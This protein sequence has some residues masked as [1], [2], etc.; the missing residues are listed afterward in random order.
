MF[1]LLPF[2]GPFAFVQ[3][4]SPGNSLSDVIQVKAKNP[5]R[6][7]LMKTYELTDTDSLHLDHGAKTF[8][9]CLKL[10]RHGKHGPVNLCMIKKK[11]L[12]SQTSTSVAASPNLFK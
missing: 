10:A 4:A 6:E 2:K 3:R 1:F 12:P 9:R 7:N 11:Q 8:A 5:T